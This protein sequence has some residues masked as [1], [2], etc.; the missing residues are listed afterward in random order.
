MRPDDPALV[1]SASDPCRVLSVPQLAALLEALRAAG[2]ALVGPTVRD[3]AVVVDRITGLE[4]LPRGVGDEQ[5]PGRYRLRARGDDALFGWAAPAT[6]PRSALFTPRATLVQIRRSGRALEMREPPRDFA[7]LALVG[8]RPCEVAAIAI[9]DRVFL[10][11]HPDADYAARRAGAFIL[12]VHCGEPASTCFCT[13]MGTGPR[14]ER[15]F[16][17]AATEL[18]GPP[19]R[20]LVEVGTAR[21]ADL[22]AQVGA[23]PA[24]EADHAAA[25]E[26]DARARSRIGRT[27]R[28]DGLREAL[29][30]NPE[31]PR[32]DDVA[33][34]CLGCASC[35]MV[36]PTCFCS[37]VE[38]T[39]DF[40][41]D[42]ATRTR[43]WDSCFTM[44][45]AH[46]HGGTVRPSLRGRY[47][48]WLTHKLSTWHDQLGTSG[49]VGCGRCMTWC[50]V[51][52]EMTVEAEA[53]AA[54]PG[55]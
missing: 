9:Q 42:E 43:R 1:S 30:A 54:G 24:E 18:L 32:W 11:A 7:P 36:C 5:A 38:D 17:L 14:A 47:R 26:V 52:I 46:V 51:G 49:C 22:L 12:T 37:T 25:A 39:T 41:G 4:D 35:T 2:F 3:G 50:P 34:R 53:V 45:F 20:F 16:D 33:A 40:T 27:L 15:G 48:Q 55:T 8:V 31:H 10:G 23:S 13:S 44:D 21:G 19:H 6:S 29:Q 28:T